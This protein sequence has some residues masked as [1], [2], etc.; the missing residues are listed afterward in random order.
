MEALSTPRFEWVG[1]KRDIGAQ[2]Q[3]GRIICMLCEHIETTKP[4][5]A[6]S[7]QLT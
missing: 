7:M 2:Q 1:A 3:R 4:T 6:Y 5:K